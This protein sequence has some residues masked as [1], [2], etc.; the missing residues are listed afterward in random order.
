MVLYPLFLQGRSSLTGAFAG[1]C[2]G[3]RA[4]TAH[5]QT[6]TVA[7]SAVATNVHQTLDVHGG[8]ATQVTFDSELGDLIANFFQIPVGQILDLL[9][10]SDATSFANFA[11][12]GATDSKDSRQANFRM[13]LR[14]NIDAS[15]TCHFRPLKLLQLTLTLLVTRIGT[16]H[17]HNALA[18]DNF[19]VTANFLDRSRNFHISLLKTFA[20]FRL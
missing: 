19:A 20:M 18:P 14:R 4:L 10:I 8:L 13:L 2:V 11:S 6:A 5:R 1:A 17:T 3:A 16:D 7:E 9:G 15:D 12:A